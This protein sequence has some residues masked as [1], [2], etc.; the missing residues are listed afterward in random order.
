MANEKNVAFVVPERTT[1]VLVSVTAYEYA[2]LVMT[3][4]RTP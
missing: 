1:T 4:E 3:C 2:G